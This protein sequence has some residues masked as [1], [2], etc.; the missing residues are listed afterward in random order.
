MCIQIYDIIMTRSVPT[1]RE[2]ENLPRH[3]SFALTTPDP[4][5]I[6]I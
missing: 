2:S 4:R 6:N 1:L 3:G 5:P